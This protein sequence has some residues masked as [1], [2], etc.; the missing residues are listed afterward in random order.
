VTADSLI[1][2]VNDITESVN[3]KDSIIKQ[4]KEQARI[5]DASAGLVGSMNQLSIDLSTLIT[6]QATRTEIAGAIQIEG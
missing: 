5:N 4:K 3:L 1:V 6:M 2:I